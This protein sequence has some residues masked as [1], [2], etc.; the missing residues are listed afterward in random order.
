[1]LGRIFRGQDIVAKEMRYYILPMIGVALLTLACMVTI[2]S[3]IA[4]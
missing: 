1:M 4:R 3:M 2:T